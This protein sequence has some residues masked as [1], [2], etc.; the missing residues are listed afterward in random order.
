[1]EI[2]DV[3]ILKAIME[4]GH[5]H[6][7]HHGDHGYPNNQRHHRHQGYVTIEEF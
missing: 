7:G 5:G 3:T 4:T 6:E 1:M 2:T